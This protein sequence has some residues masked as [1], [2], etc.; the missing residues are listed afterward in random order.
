MQGPWGIIGTGRKIFSVFAA[1]AGINARVRLSA[2]ASVPNTKAGFFRPCLLLFPRSYFTRS[3]FGRKMATT[4]PGLSGNRLNERTARAFPVTESHT[5]S[6]E[7]AAS[8]L[9]S[10][11]QPSV[12]RTVAKSR[13]ANP[14]IVKKRTE[15][16]A[17]S[18]AEWTEQPHAQLYL[19]ASSPPDPFHISAFPG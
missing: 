17:D 7:A 15:S 14:E 4:R 2:A 18:A 19:P 10:T 3:R 1:G 9:M 5:M 11:E 16:F 6:G 12:F 13:A 8:M